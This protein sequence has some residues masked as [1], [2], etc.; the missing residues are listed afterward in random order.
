MNDSD[1]PTKSYGNHSHRFAD[2]SVE[3]KICLIIYARFILWSHQSSQLQRY[4]GFRPVPTLG[5]QR[6][7]NVVS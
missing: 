5:S 7:P 1:L 4:I 2:G 6:D 3:K